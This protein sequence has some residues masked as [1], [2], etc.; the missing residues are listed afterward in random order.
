M[1]L[2][3]LGRMLRRFRGDGGTYAPGRRTWS[4]MNGMNGMIIGSQ[5]RPGSPPPG[6]R[7]K[8]IV[9]WLIVLAVVFVVVVGALISPV[10]PPGW[11][12]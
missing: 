11:S 3:H 6:K 7:R 4:V 12:K 2:P 9:V 10:P 5:F 1:A 8:E